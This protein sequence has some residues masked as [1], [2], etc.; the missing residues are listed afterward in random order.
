MNKNYKTMCGIAFGSLVFLASTIMPASAQ[1]PISNPLSL[2]PPVGLPVVP[3]FEGAYENEDGSVSYS[4][5][6]LNRNTG[7][8]VSV[9]L[10]QNNPHRCGMVKSGGISRLAAIAN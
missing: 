3:I 1:A 5:G 9:P 10:G 2:T 6:Y 7:E 8:P 4:F